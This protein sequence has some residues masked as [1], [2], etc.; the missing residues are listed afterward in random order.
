MRR[1]TLFT[2]RLM[3]F[4]VMLS[5]GFAANGCGSSSPPAPRGFKFR[6]TYAMVQPEQK[7][8]LSF[9][10]ANLEIRFQID[11]AAIEFEL[12]NSTNTPFMIDWPRAT[13]GV[14][15][16]FTPVRHSDNYGLDEAL[17]LKADTV[18]PGG[19]VRD[20]AIPRD[21]LVSRN[22]KA[23]EV[24]LF[25]T[26]DLNSLERRKQIAGNVGNRLALRMPIEIGG[27]RTNYLFEFKIASVNRIL[28]KNYHPSQRTPKELPKKLKPSTID[29]AVAAIITAGVVG[30]AAIVVSAKK[31]PRTD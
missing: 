21:H 16:K 18:L 12:K 25:P 26:A 2:Y 24:D 15:S 14:D 27:A 20:F 6:Y 10:D 30:L 19:V 1:A 31:E 13:V 23:V 11:D 29:V 22:D 4:G 28:W 9:A 8:D 5:L 17:E 7:P 3:L